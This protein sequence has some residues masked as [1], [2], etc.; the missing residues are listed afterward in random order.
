ML[1]HV[2][3]PGTP[4]FAQDMLGY[5]FFCLATLATA[6]VFTGGKLEAWIKWLLTLNGILFAIPTMI[7]PALTLPTNEAG[8]GLGNQVGSYA[9]MIWVHF[10]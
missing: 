10:V 9:N 3:I 4:I 6:P 1:P 8:T 2:F 5:V 7:L